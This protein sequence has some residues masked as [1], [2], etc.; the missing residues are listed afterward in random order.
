ML[1]PLILCCLMVNTAKLC[2]AQHGNANLR[3]SKRDNYTFDLPSHLMQS[4]NHE[5]ILTIYQDLL[6][7]A[8]SVRGSPHLNLFSAHA[9]M[10]NTVRCLNGIQTGKSL[11]EKLTLT[12]LLWFGFH[13]LSIHFF[14][15]IELV[16][17]SRTLRA[18]IVVDRC[19]LCPPV[20]F[21]EYYE[22]KTFSFFLCI[23]TMYIKF[24]NIFY[25]FVYF[26]NKNRKQDLI[27]CTDSFFFLI[28]MH[29]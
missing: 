9:Q 18:C 20:S 27:M 23:N 3:P 24:P 22:F 19:L 25:C 28:C 13:L 11:I 8:P 4:G 12:L 14:D 17:K 10:L 5:C 1:R 16:I 29:Q 15:I 21:A 2:S 7:G 26:K 6:N